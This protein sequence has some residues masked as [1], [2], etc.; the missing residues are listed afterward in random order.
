MPSPIRRGRNQITLARA[1][2][3]LGIA[4]RTQAEKL[5]RDGKVKV[6]GK[7]V[8]SPSVWVD[9]RSERITVAETAARPAVHRYFV[10]NK[11]VGVVTTRSDEL[12][13]MTVYDLLPK[14][15]PWMFPVGRLDKDSSGLLLLTND[16][17]LGER[18]SAPLYKVPK[19]YRVELD[20]PLADEDRRQLE[21]PMTLR[22]GTRLQPATVQRY[23]RP[24][25]HIEITI[26]EGK[27]RQIRRMLQ[28]LG[29]SVIALQ[30][31]RIGPIELG[32]LPEGKLRPLTDGEMK[33]LAELG[34]LRT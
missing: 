29:Y 14:N 2:S 13:R 15:L 25:S 3:K 5:I 33:A 20:R 11:P 26:R 6:N 21:S 1:L 32:N 28:Q 8:R 34:I 12:G 16:T 10:L 23:R 27:N 17:R 24:T 4:S 30:R 9:P 22:N 19:T 18:I 7:L 31:I